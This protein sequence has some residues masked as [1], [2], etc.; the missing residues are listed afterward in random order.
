[1]VGGLAEPFHG[2]Q[3]LPHGFHVDAVHLLLGGQQVDLA[4][5]FLGGDFLAAG[6]QF[7]QIPG[8]RVIEDQFPAVALLE[9]FP[10]L[11]LH[12]GKLLMDGLV[13][14]VLRPHLPALGEDSDPALGLDDLSPQ[15]IVAGVHIGNFFMELLHGLDA[16]GLQKIEQGGALLQSPDFA[17]AGVRPLEL[18][19]GLPQ[20]HHAGLLALRL[21]RLGLRPVVEAGNAG[22]DFFQQLVVGGDLPVDFSLVGADA[23][24]LH[25]AGRWPQ[26]DRGDFINALALVAAVVYQGRLTG[27]LQCPVGIGRPCRPPNLHIPFVV[28]VGG[29]LPVVL[30]AA[31]PIRDALA[32]LVQVVCLAALRAPCAIFF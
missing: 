17:G 2:F 6:F 21:L 31:F 18:L 12:P 32:V 28:P 24:L 27:G 30:P 4:P 29:V 8:R 10:L 26:V 14:V 22:L 23:A 7:L 11:R 5:P 25:L 20:V 1:M 3:F 13:L 15:V 19:L 16:V 9:Q